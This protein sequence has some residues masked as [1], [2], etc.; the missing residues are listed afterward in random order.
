M[1]QTL[2]GKSTVEP[3]R[4][5]IPKAEVGWRWVANLSP[6][7]V[8]IEKADEFLAREARFDSDLWVIEVEDRQGRPFLDDSLV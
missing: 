4:H 1:H 2:P 5:S 8:E 7:G 6:A 3:P